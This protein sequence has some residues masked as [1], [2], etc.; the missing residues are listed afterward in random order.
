MAKAKKATKKATPAGQNAPESG[1]AKVVQVP[2]RVLANGMLYAGAHHAKGKQM[3]IPKGD[4]EEL[5]AQGSV[6]ILPGLA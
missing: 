2:C 4:A 6:E 5:K 1:A 3:A